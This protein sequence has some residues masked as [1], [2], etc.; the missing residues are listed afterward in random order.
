VGETIKKYNLVDKGEK[1]IVACS[2]GKD[3]TTVLYLLKKFG[4]D[5]E[6]MFIDLGI[7]KW[8]AANKKNLEEFCEKQG[9]TLHCVSVRDELGYSIC[10]LRSISEKKAGLSSCNACGIIKRWLINKKA[11]DFGADKVATGHNMD[12]EAETIFMNIIKGSPNLC[13]NLGPKTGTEKEKKFVTRIKPLYFCTEKEVEQYSR[14][15]QFPVLYDK[16]PC[17]VD[18]YRRQI[19]NLLDEFEARHKGTRKNIVM[20]FM[21]ILPEL[22]KKYKTKKKIEYCKYCGEPSRGEKCKMCQI[23]EL[24]VR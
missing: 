22:R 4:Y 18:A 12:D 5:I 14:K 3:S 21:K 20:H 16:C 8:S 6:A 19:K 1:I 23:L 15:M 24:A 7:G 13:I 2:G 17:S 11:R 9:I 10:Y